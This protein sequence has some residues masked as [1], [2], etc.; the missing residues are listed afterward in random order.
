MS[1]VDLTGNT[2]VGYYTVLYQGGTIVDTQFTPASFTANIGQTYTVLV[3]D[4]GSCSFDHWQDTGSA[5][6]QRDVTPDS[7]GGVSFVAVYNCATKSTVEE[8]TTVNA[9]GNNLPGYF[10]TLMSPSGIVLQSC[11][12]PCSFTVNNGEAYVVT[13]ANFGSETFNHWS[14]NTGNIYSWGGSYNVATPSGSTGNT[15]SL[16]AVYS[17]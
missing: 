15:V 17:P 10:V 6:R 4:Y 1:T 13:V 14:D 9:A 3:D 12:S 2:I 16:T 8:V 7:I 5:V 11:Y